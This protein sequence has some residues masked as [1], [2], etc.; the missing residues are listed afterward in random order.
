MTA[1]WLPKLS[2]LVG[3]RGTVIRVS[4]VS[5]DGSSPREV[6]AFMNVTDTSFEGTVGGGALENEAQA[7]CRRMLA[8]EHDSA[9]AMW[10]RRVIEYPLGPDLGQCCGGYVRL[11]YEVIGKAEIDALGPNL[12]APQGAMNGFAAR[13]FVSGAALQIFSAD[14]D[15]PQGWYAEPLDAK[16]TP[17]YLYGAGH[18][19][20]AVVH[21]MNGLPFEIHWVDTEAG[22]FPDPIPEGVRQIV[23]AGPE[24][25]P[26]RARAG[27]FHVVMTFSHGIDFEVCRAVLASD[28]FAYLGLI[29]SATKQARFSKRL[30][31]AGFSEDMLERLHCPIGLAGLSGKEPAVIAVSLAAD[32]LLRLS[33]RATAGERVPGEG[34]SS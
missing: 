2:R 31:D 29:G 25:V 14:Q 6:G 23:A 3:D 11:M 34:A 33:A 20:R 7:V 28:N 15:I 10:R 8:E 17:L 32:L 18:V 13:P 12:T 9:S 5:V 19:G 4:V 27:A 24:T 26:S 1:G 21:A 16:L 30:R 22:R